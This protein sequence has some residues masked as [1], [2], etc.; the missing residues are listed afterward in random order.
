MGPCPQQRPHDDSA[1][2]AEW[3]GIAR[4]DRRCWSYPRHAHVVIVQ[5]L[6]ALT[7]TLADARDT[8]ALG[9]LLRGP[10][11]GL[12]EEELLDATDALPPRE[13]GRAGQ[14]S[15]WTPVEHVGHS[16]LCETLAILQGLAR[17]ASGTTP[18]VLLCQAVEEMQVRPLLRRRREG[19]AER[20][21]ANIDQ[22]LEAARPYDL[23]GLQAFAQAMNEQWKD[24]QRSMEGRPDTEQQSV[25]LV[26][27]HAAK[28]LEWPVVVPVNMGG[29]LKAQVQ[30]ALD[31][32]GRL[33][34]P[35]FGLRGPGSAEALQA[36]RDELERE[37]HR[38]WYVAA[39]RA[40]DLLLLPDFSTGV[41][42]NSWMERF[43]LR[44][45]GLHP[46][47]PAGLPPGQL[48]GREEHPNTQDRR[49]FETE[50]ALIVSRA[51][52]ILRV[53]PHLA[54]VGDAEET[55]SGPL[56]SMSEDPADAATPARGSLARGLVLHKLLEEVLTGEVTE[57]E[58]KLQ[59]RAA[60]LATQ[61]G[62]VP[63]AEELNANE[64][65]RTVLRGLTL[66]EIVAVRD[67]L[68]P[69]CTVAASETT[70]EAEHVTLGVAD[71]VVPETD[72][73]LSLVVDWKSD[74]DPAPE[75][76]AGYKT[77]VAAYLAATGARR[78]LIVF[79]SLGRLVGVG[80]ASE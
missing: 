33:H 53:T 6:I 59:A 49:T 69:E 7:R 30:A 23:R 55:D 12:T 10:L 35:V 41:P 48:D 8:L 31:P 15:L 77:Q 36:E 54:E 68:V 72:G 46:F 1:I 38:I 50:A 26:T 56:P 57:E 40:R 27:M 65:A 61:L 32:E 20:A 58:E 34:L 19:T 14:L 43:G 78:G 42:R 44:H 67:R 17:A 64:A 37:R 63:G 22:F 76:V 60:E 28:G 24:A 70:D 66:P 71:A 79:L 29:E 5:D 21:L 45:A 4:A 39:T 51:H 3:C 73:A 52:R 13:D 75:T 47:D 80:Q 16:L 9:A 11:V 62:N 18:F 2:Q 25:S 74:V